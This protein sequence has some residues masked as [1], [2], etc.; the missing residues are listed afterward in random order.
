MDSSWPNSETA[1][2]LRCKLTNASC[3]SFHKWDRHAGRIYPW[4]NL[5][6]WLAF[7]KY[8]KIFPPKCM[9][10]NYQCAVFQL[11]RKLRP[12]CLAEITYKVW[13]RHLL[14]MT[15]LF[16][17]NNGIMINIIAFK[18]FKL[19]PRK[20]LSTVQHFWKVVQRIIYGFKSKLF[21]TW[22]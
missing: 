13:N 16:V 7:R 19:T 11:N 18:S 10:W 12:P 5:L 17:V 8:E 22:K 20:T 6:K 3:S 2:T 1:A 9:P 4:L 14:I 15:S 21:I